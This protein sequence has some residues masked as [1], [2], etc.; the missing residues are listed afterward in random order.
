[1]EGFLC[2]DAYKN[3]KKNYL[4]LL[5]RNKENPNLLWAI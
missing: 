5:I 4:R 2:H 3:L 1:M